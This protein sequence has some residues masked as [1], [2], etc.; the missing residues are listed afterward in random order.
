MRKTVKNDKVLRAIT[1]GLA[2]MIA[3]TSAPVSVF[4]EDGEGE[5]GGADSSSASVSSEAHEE[6]SESSKTSKT[7]NPGKPDTLT[8][9]GSTAASGDDKAAPDTGMSYAPLAALGLIAI[10]ALAVVAFKKR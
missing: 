2:T 7:S 5:S 1:I 9:G 6:S 8:M 3:A 10:S 4:A